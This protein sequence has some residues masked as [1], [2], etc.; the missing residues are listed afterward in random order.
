MTDFVRPILVVEDRATDLDLTK[1]AFERRQIQ[2]PILEA[3]NGEEAMAFLQRWDAGEPLPL[4][5]LLDVR[6]PKISGLEVLR[7]LKNHP[8]YS[9]IPVIILTTSTED[10][11]VS[12]AYKFG[13]NS[14]IVKP[15]KFEQFMQLAVQIETYWCA[16]NMAPRHDSGE[17]R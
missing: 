17:M 16:L 10:S 9:A 8:K 4:F 11:D 2:N 5:I 1:R 3:R 14:Y 6:L 15:S 7:N 12:N 13:C